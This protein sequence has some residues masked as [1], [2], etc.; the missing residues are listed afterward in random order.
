MWDP[1]YAPD[2]DKLERIQKQAARF[3]TGNYKSREEGSITN[4]LKDLG[5]E[6]LKERRSF[7]GLEFFYNVAEG[8]IPPIP[9]DEF[10]QSVRARHQIKAKNIQ[11]ETANIIDR[12]VETI[13]NIGNINI[14]REYNVEQCR[15]EQYKNSFFVRR[16]V[17]RNH[18]DNSVVHAE[19]VEGFKSALGKCYLFSLHALSLQ[20]GYS[21][22]DGMGLGKNGVCNPLHLLKIMTDLC[23]ATPESYT[24]MIFIDFRRKSVSCQHSNMCLSINPDPDPGVLVLS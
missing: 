21:T 16:T 6:P 15:I 18:L 17:D 3:I 12:Q 8:L 10:L 22:L 1:Y 19:T 14:N 23:A 9:P 7:N 20:K 24:S 2:I 11:T 4:M 13:G 5:I